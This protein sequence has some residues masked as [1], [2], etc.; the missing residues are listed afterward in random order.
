[1]ITC[2]NGRSERDSFLQLQLVLPSLA[3]LAFF[4]FW[5]FPGPSQAQINEIRNGGGKQFLCMRTGLSSNLQNC[6]AR[7]DW[8]T[9]VFV[10]SITAIS[11]GGNDESKIEIHPEEVFYGNPPD[12]VS[13]LTS[14]GLCF[15]KLEM[16]DRWLFYLRKVKDDPIVLD[17][18][19]NDSL[20]VNDASKQINTFRR[21]QAIG[22]R[23]ILRGRVWR[24]TLLEGEPVV[25]ARITVKGGA[26]NITSSLFSDANGSFEFPPLP[27]GSYKI[28]VDHIGEFRPEPESLEIVNGGCWDLTFSQ[29][30]WAGISGYVKFPDGSPARGGQIILYRV[31]DPL[32][33]TSHVDGYG[34]YQFDTLASGSYVI[35]YR[36]MA[37]KFTDTIGVVGPPPAASYYPGVPSR[38]AATSLELKTDQRL[39]EINITLPKP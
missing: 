25:N 36:S 24:R 39:V 14:Q 3:L 21:L 15:R 13:V 5:L 29:D 17:Y 7:S 16:G 20:P 28:S 2:H 11:P 1:M 34:F 22:S 38:A 26:G 12:P 27:P 32:W 35:G 8:Y 6:G 37:E 30:A 23:G 33:A 4:V 9:Y 10:G 18:Y 19:G 31:G